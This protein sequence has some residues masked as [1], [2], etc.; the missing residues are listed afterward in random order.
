MQATEANQNLCLRMP[1]GQE[2]KTP[3]RQPVTSSHPRFK[4]QP[5]QLF[6]FF[7]SIICI[8]LS[9]A[10]VCRMLPA[11]PVQQ[12]PVQTG[13]CSKTEQNKKKLKFFN[14]PQFLFEKFLALSVPNPLKTFLDNFRQAEIALGNMYSSNQYSKN[15]AG[16]ANI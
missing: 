3:R 8:I 14:I 10:P 15:P 7:A 4:L 1:Q 16:K 13:F 2:I 9:P 11:L 6:P 5:T 12:C